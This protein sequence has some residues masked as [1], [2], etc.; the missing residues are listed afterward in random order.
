M[1]STISAIS[2]THTHTNTNTNTNTHIHT[3]LGWRPEEYNQKVGSGY[4]L[5]RNIQFLSGQKS[6]HSD[7]WPRSSIDESSYLYNCVRE[8]RPNR[9]GNHS[10][11]GQLPHAH[12]RNK[13]GQHG[14][15]PGGNQ[16]YSRG[17]GDLGT[18]LRHDVAVPK[19]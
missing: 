11:Y 19:I 1:L 4:D 9:I 5:N 15:Y 14:Q 10:V 7:Q 3:E 17:G 13:P 12:N 2:Y 16:P 18:H 8:V 6:G